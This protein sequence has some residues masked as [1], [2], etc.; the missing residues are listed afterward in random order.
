MKCL[1]TTTGDSIRKIYDNVSLENPTVAEQIPF[2]R[3]E[4]VMRARRQKITP[5]NPTNFAESVQLLSGAVTYNKHLVH[6][7]LNDQEGAMLFATEK[8]LETANSPDVK[9]GMTDAT[10]KCCPKKTQ[11]CEETTQG[12]IRNVLSLTK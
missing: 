6:V 11:R 9:V 10:F 8:G 7:I 3:M 5:R 4:A 1:A 12:R 2:P